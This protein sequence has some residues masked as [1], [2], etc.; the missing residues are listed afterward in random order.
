MKSF[1]LLVKCCLVA[2]GL[3]AIRATAVPDD[4]KFFPIELVCPFTERNGTLELISQNS[5]NVR[6]RV[7]VAY[8]NY[9]AKYVEVAGALS[10]EVIQHLITIDV[11]TSNSKVDQD[12]A[13]EL[14]A[15]ANAIKIN[16]CE[17]TTSNR[18]RY[19]SALSKNK[20]IFI[21]GARAKN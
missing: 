10:G 14:I 4:S 19:L 12:W 8:L 2:V 7:R 13:A 3:S 15:K 20:S 16:V 6:N 5:K 17:G 1:N 9:T 11:D 21:D 18:Q